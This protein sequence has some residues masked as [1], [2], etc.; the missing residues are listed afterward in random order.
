MIGK[1]APVDKHE[2]TILEK[3]TDHSS[4]I[5]DSNVDDNTLKNAI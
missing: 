3:E 5:N 4:Y 2:D 1:V